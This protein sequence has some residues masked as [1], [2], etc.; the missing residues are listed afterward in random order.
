MTSIALRGKSLRP[1]MST[2]TQDGDLKVIRKITPMKNSKQVR[3]FWKGNKFSYMDVFLEQSVPVQR[4]E[5]GGGVT[6]DPEIVGTP[7]F[8]VSKG[9]G[10]VTVT[11]VNDQEQVTSLERQ[12][13]E[14]SLE[15]RDLNEQLSWLGG[16]LELEERYSSSLQKLVLTKFTKEELLELALDRQSD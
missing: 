7:K 1:G 10:P 9:E 6:F 16:L 13:E 4:R 5:D 12:S 14:A 8:D 2:Y 3:I 15:I 11:W